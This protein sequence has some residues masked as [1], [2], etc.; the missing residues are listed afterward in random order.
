MTA[1]DMESFDVT[2]MKW[3]RSDSLTLEIEETRFSHGAFRDA[4]RA[5]TVDKNVAQ[6][7]W[8]VKQYQEK[9]STAIKDDLGMSLED[10]TR[11][12][13]QMNAVA[14][15]LTKKFAKNV[16]PEFGRTFEY[17][18]VFF[19]V[20][21]EQPVTVEEYVEGEFQ[22][23]VN[24]NG[25][26]ITSPAEGFDEIYAKAQCLVH[27]SYHRS[28]R[29]LMLLDIQ[30]SSF[31]LYDPEIAT[32]DLLANNE[33]LGSKE[34]NFCAGNL[35]CVAIDSFKSKHICNIYCEMMSI[36]QFD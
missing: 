14:R 9:A 25:M 19:A 20:F 11:K 22:K 27:F 17:I 6:T 13:V 15:H 2:E 5:T 26:C 10:H 34:V 36:E 16:P 7:K 32:T 35:S 31:K 12:Q 30:G 24:N 18:K 33:S 8:V 21:K 23:Y 29:K 4:F 1:L 28:E 3:V